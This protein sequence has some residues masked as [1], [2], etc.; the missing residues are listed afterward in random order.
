VSGLAITAPNVENQSK[1]QWREK[2]RSVIIEARVEYGQ[3]A[4]TSVAPNAGHTT[5]WDARA[6]QIPNRATTQLCVQTTAL[7]SRLSVQA[8]AMVLRTG[9]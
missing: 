1:H 4:M 8:G 6:N 2:S 5:K 3:T 7:G 9:P